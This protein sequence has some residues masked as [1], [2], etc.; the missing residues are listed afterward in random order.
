MLVVGMFFQAW[1]THA[2]T[3]YLCDVMEGPLITEF[4]RSPIRVF[5][6]VKRDVLDDGWVSID[7][8][9][10]R[11][12]VLGVIQAPPGKVYKFSPKISMRKYRDLMDL[13]SRGVLPGIMLLTLLQNFFQCFLGDISFAQRWGPPGVVSFNLTSGFIVYA[14]VVGILT[15]RVK[16]AYGRYTDYRWGFGIPSPVAWAVQE[17]PS[18]WIPTAVLYRNRHTI[19]ESEERFTGAFILS[20]FIGHYCNRTFAFPL[21][22]NPSSKAVPV[23]TVVSAFF[24]TSF[25]GFLQ[26]HY[27]MEVAKYSSFQLFVLHPSTL[28]GFVLFVVGLLW[29]IESDSILRSLRRPGEKGY[30]IPHGGLFQFISAPNYFSEIVEWWGFWILSEFSYPAFAFAL[31]TSLFLGIRGYQH[32]QWYLEKFGSE[33]PRSRKAIIPLIL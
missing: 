19:F 28:L 32:H 30:K 17:F 21:L 16:A 22:M 25:N 10:K 1:M 33:Y 12:R 4:L 24:F 13:L 29:N 26:A 6:L 18:F 23:T 27:F 8:G 14:L 20:F 15:S 2:I 9:R 5:V 11:G 3:Q 7:V 31:F